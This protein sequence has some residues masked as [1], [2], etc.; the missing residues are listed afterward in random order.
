MES[1]LIVEDEII[2][3]FSLKVM[4]SRKGY[5]VVDIV[6]TGEDAIR[7]YQTHSPEV[8]LMD[9]N[10]KGLM[11]GTDAALEIIKSG[12]PRIIFVSAYKKE[13]VVCEPELQKY[14]FL[15]KPLDEGILFNVLQ[16]DL[17]A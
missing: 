10:L 3:S 9:I 15:K 1:V 7:S 17:F 4:L 14:E 11:T 13:E 2:I 6:R 16:T 12:S 5:K 8:I